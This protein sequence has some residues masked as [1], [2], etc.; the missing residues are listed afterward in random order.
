MA[1]GHQDCGDPLRCDDWD[2]S[3]LEITK[4]GPKCRSGPTNEYAGPNEQPTSL[5]SKSAYGDQPVVSFGVDCA[6]HLDTQLLSLR[7][8]ELAAQLAAVVAQIPDA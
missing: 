6:A 4:A 7:Q 5:V 1:G 8:S 2:R 3:R